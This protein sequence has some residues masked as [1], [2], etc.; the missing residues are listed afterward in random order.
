MIRVTVEIVPF[1]LE[2]GRKVIATAEIA[3]DGKHPRRPTHGSYTA[4]L[5]VHQT[6]KG[7][8]KL[9]RKARVPQMHRHQRGVWDLL[10]LVLKDA[11]GDRNAPELRAMNSQAKTP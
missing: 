2:I 11:L 8:P 4:K 10:Q 5:Y 1:G 3:N 6:A 9:W 7:K